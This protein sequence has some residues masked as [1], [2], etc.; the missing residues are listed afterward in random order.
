MRLAHFTILADTRAAAR[1]GGQRAGHAQ[2]LRRPGG[3]VPD[4]GGTGLPGQFRLQSSTADRA[5]GRRRDGRRGCGQHGDRPGAGVHRPRPGTGRCADLHA[6]VT[7]PIDSLVAQV[8]QSSYTT[9][10][11]DL[12]YTH[13]GRQSRPDGAGA[14]PGAGQYLLVLRRT[15][16][17][18]VAGTVRL[19]LPDVLQRGR[20][21][22][23]R[24]AARTTSTW[25]APITIR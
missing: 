10:H 21:P 1:G 9:L 20:R 17:A 16:T 15:G 14:R 24:H 5:T 2:R 6:T 18:N 4:A 23:R 22:S 25:S 8:S 11:Q 13:S 7:M 19:Q 3:G 12:L